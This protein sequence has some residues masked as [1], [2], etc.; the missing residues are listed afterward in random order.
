M[1][2]GTLILRSMSPDFILTD[3][4][5]TPRKVHLVERSF[6]KVRIFDE[7]IHQSDIYRASLEESNC[8]S[9]TSKEKNPWLENRVTERVGLIAI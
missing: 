6:W 3:D 9:Q 2:T 7:F 4:N 5:P 8:N 1:A